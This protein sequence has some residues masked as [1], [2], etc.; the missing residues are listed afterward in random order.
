MEGEKTE[1]PLKF[2]FHQ[3]LA[4]LPILLYVVLSG[5]IM[6]CFHYY[7]MKALVLAAVIALLIGFLL[8][9]TKG[10]YWD[11]VV[12]GLA[13]YGNARLILIF[14]VIG[15]FS[16][17][18]VSGGIG[19]GFIWVG[20]SLHLT[21]GGFVVF[22]FLVSGLISM[23]AGAPIAALLAVIPI[24]YPAGVLLGANPAILT[25]AM[26]SGVFFGDAMSPSSQVIHTTVASQHE[27]VTHES[28]KLL[29]TMK[30]RLPYLLGAGLLS[31][32]LFF[33]FGGT[34]G[35]L[36]DMK[37]L[38]SLCDPRGLWMLIPIAVLLCICFRTSNLFLG[39]T[40]G[41]IAGVIVGVV[42]GL[43]HMPDLISIHYDTQELHGVLFDGISGVIDIIIS[44]I[45]LYGLIGI[46]VEGGRMDSCC[47]YLTSRKAIQHTQGAE[48]MI[49]IGVGIV[50]VFLAGCVL[51]SIIMFKDVADTIGIEANI[52]AG[53]R[54][55]L[56]TAMTTNVTAIVPINSA[57]VMSAVTI[58]NQLSSANGQL[59]T[60][61]PFAIFL[62]TY[63]CLLLTL[64]CF[65]WVKGGLG[66][67]KGVQEK[68]ER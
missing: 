8:C 47:K 16:K 46:T 23:G 30:K 41:I 4:L 45:L 50:N 29:E 54:A 22:C 42:T 21:G 11:A 24:F 66:R 63:Y 62:S 3:S 31:A 44:T 51:P 38:Q 40:W 52:P 37:E 28:A 7:S 6:V 17:L 34:N 57:F 10:I 59:P 18:L 1:F 32:I 49:S 58:I 9:S 26:L 19:S 48:A 27:P 14:M 60:V 65:L 5:V 68:K 53:R 2:H 56:M 55:I 39:V 43:F 35:T 20:M 13:Q 67:Q 64:V 25:G 36:G 61:S 12:R 15:I 33:I